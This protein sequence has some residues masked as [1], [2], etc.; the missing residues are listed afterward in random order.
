MFYPSPSLASVATPA[1][2]RQ[3]WAD[4]EGILTARLGTEVAAGPHSSVEQWSGQSQYTQSASS[5]VGVNMPGNRWSVRWAGRSGRWGGRSVRWGGRSVRWRGRSVRWRGRSVRWGGRCLRG[6]GE[7]EEDPVVHSLLQPRGRNILPL[8]LQSGFWYSE[9]N[10]PP[11]SQD[12]ARYVPS[13]NMV[14][15]YYKIWRCSLDQSGRPERPAGYRWFILP[16]DVGRP[17]LYRTVFISLT[18]IAAELHDWLT[19]RSANGW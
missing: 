3:C 6:P 7:D 17:R 4:N 18:C 10:S 8:G 14:S 19:G 5:P 9:H 15:I 16:P 2:A 1:L 12:S 11:G 13:Y